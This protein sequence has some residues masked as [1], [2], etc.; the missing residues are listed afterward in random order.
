MTEDTF[1]KY[2]TKLLPSDAEMDEL[3]NASVE[4]LSKSVETSG[5]DFDLET[6]ELKKGEKEGN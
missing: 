6:L 3:V 4:A 2:S 5:P 1:P